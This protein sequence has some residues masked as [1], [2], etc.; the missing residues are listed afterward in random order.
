M[1]AVSAILIP[2]ILMRHDITRRVGIGVHRALCGLFDFIGG[3]DDAGTGHRGGQAAWAVR[4]RFIWQGAAMMWPCITPARKMQPKKRLRPN[5]AMGRRAEPL[6]ADLLDE[7]QTTD[8][9]ARAAAALG[10]PLTVLINNA[11]IFEYDSITRA[12]RESWDRHM[13]SNLRAPFVLTQGFAAQA[14]DGGHRCGGRTHCAIADHQHDRPTRA[15]ADARVHDLYAGQD[16]SLGTDPHLG[17]GSW[18]RPSASM[19]LVPAL[20]CKAHARRMSTLHRSAPDTILGRGA[21]PADITAALGYFLDS[22]AVTGQ[23]LCVDGGQ[24]LGWQTPDILGV[25]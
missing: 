20:P 19:P 1:L 8:L 15:K 16:G 21:N 2:F 11:S 24:H 3:C 10:G 13:E 25:E 22:P 12:T 9:I 6:Q 4:W 18:P 5:P 23:L 7:G 14:P 17:A